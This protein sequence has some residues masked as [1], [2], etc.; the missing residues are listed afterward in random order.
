MK[1]RLLPVSVLAVLLAGSCSKSDDTPGAKPDVSVSTP[2][3]GVSTASMKVVRI[4]ATVKNE[5]AS[6]SFMWKLGNDTLAT[7]KE[8]LYAFTKAGDYS[9][10]FI[11]K[12]TAGEQR[13][14]VPVKVTA[15]K[16]TN[17]VTRVFDYLPA[18]GQ[19]VHDLP[20]WEE[21]DDQ[22][23]MTA[24]AE[25]SLKNGTM[26]HLGGFGGYVV[27]GFDHTIVNVP[28][29]FNFTVLGNAFLNWSE[30]GIIEVAY[31]A[32]G[33]GLPDDEWFEIAGSEYKSPKTIHNYSITYY[34]PDENKVK[35]PNNNYVYL[36][37][38]TYIRW[39]DNQGKSGY[40]SKNSFHSQSYYPQWKGDSI[41]F[42]G[43]R[44]TDENI[45]DKSGKGSF[46]VSP[47]VPFGYADNWNNDDPNARI[48]ISWAVDKKGN[49][50]K[51]PGVDFIR[52]YTGMRAEGGWLGEIST[53]V[54]GVTDLNL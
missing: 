28:D 31:D 39:K 30:P 12:N 44:L 13:V 34:K 21:G 26:I 45:V 38:T 41:T 20:K 24:K 4:T 42:T 17:G 19:F 49:S 1:S 7:T 46:Y 47:A 22:A 25:E 54:S 10:T 29:S 5:T 33:N 43:T 14:D 50:V 23:K 40:L 2:Q 52:V 15:L 27:M 8:L 37:D 3:G 51:L 32:N 6:T 16:Y 36:I 48:K 9:L 35:T 53:E 11:A 18:P